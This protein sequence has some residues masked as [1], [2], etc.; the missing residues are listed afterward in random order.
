MPDR[1]FSTISPTARG[2]LYMKAITTKI[3][4][5]WEAAELI[6]GTSGI[7]FEC[8]YVSI[9][10]AIDGLSINNF[11]E[12]AS[13]YSFRSLEMT[14]DRDCFYL[15]T[16]LPELIDSKRELAEAILSRESRVE[17]RLPRFLALNALDES[18]FDDACNVIPTGPICIINE[19]LLVYLDESEKRRLCALIYKILVERGGVWVTGDI[20]TRRPPDVIPRPVSSE[21]ARFLAQ[22]KVVENSFDSFESAMDFFAQC[23]FAAERHTADEVY[24]GLSSLEAARRLQ[25]IDEEQLRARL[26]LRQTWVLRPQ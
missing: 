5:L 2:L 13:G 20:Y 10:R 25:P 16:D 26:N 15:D 14:R 17:G 24:D 21:V 1:D 19:G 22:H 6:M 4:Y 8:R 7:D 9:D 3:P 18:A 12:L 23:G 11:M